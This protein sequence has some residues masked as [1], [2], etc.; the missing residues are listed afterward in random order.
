VSKR[1]V[2]SVKEGVIGHIVMKHPQSGKGLKLLGK[3]QILPE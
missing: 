1:R 2:E 3:T